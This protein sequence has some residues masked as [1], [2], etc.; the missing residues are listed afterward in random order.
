M[1]SPRTPDRQTHAHDISIGFGLGL[2]G[3]SHNP[4]MNRR[5]RVLHVLLP[6]NYGP[7]HTASICKFSVESCPACMQCLS[8]KSTEATSKLKICVT[9]DMNSLANSRDA[10][11]FAA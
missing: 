10:E 11:M 9:F 3:Q 8:G 5:A 2:V 6:C 7:L 1:S 4:Q